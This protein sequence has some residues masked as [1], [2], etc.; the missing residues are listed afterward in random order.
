[1]CCIVVE[2]LKKSSSQE[3]SACA[4]RL[5]N[6]KINDKPAVNGFSGQPT[7]VTDAAS[8]PAACTGASTLFL[9]L[10]LKF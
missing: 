9:S 7:N 4:S 3:T 8:R 5:K 6:V 10:C 2:V 1:M